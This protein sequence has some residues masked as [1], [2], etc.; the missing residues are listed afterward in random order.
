MMLLGAFFTVSFLLTEPQAIPGGPPCPHSHPTPSTF[1][2]QRPSRTSGTAWSLPEAAPAHH[3]AAP[4]PETAKVP[5]LPLRRRRV[6]L[7]APTTAS[8]KQPDRLSSRG[9]S[10]LHGRRGRDYVGGGR[11]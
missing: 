6:Q 10:H 5:T 3:R 2:H 11:S 4:G 9:S 8:C 7:P 1:S